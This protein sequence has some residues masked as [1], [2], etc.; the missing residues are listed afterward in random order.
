V[1]GA[2]KY[3]ASLYL[4]SAL[5]GGV[6]GMALFLPL[7]AVTEPLAAHVSPYLPGRGLTRTAGNFML[8]FFFAFPA[9][10]L[11]ALLGV[12]SARVGYWIRP[13]RWA[14]LLAAV[15]GGVASAFL[16]SLWM[17]VYVYQGCIW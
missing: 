2:P 16:V 12:I 8:V 4:L 10:D 17:S 14:A 6:M 13:R 11:G 3:S 1:S 9:S 15:I 5:I 7:S